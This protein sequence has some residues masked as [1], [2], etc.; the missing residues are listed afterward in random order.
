MITENAHRF[1]VAYDITNDFRR[2]R[3]AKVLESFGDRV[4]Y[5]VFLVDAK[6]AKLIRLEGALRRLMDLTVDSVMICDLGS[7]ATEATRL[8]FI[9]RER[10]YTGD[11]PLIL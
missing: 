5:S 1:V 2:D 4:Q 9:G 10:S 3:I 8:N 6:P 7:I 11:G